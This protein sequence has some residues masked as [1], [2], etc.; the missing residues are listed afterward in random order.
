M[1]EKIEDLNIR[2]LNQL[3]LHLSRQFRYELKAG[4]QAHEVAELHHHLSQVH[5]LLKTRRF[6]CLTTYG[7]DV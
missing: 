1:M 6:H 3:F 5:Q 7:F 4:K 2:E